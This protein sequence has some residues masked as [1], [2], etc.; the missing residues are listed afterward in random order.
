MDIQC[1][2]RFDSSCSRKVR[3]SHAA[4]AQ[5]RIKRIMGSGFAYAAESLASYK[6]NF[7][8][9]F[10]IGHQFCS[11]HARSAGRGEI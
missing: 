8:N 7:C 1:F 10:H 2:C 3:F 6:C 9:G 11:R 4:H 5:A